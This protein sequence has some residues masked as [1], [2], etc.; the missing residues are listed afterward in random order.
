MSGGT[1]EIKV[2]LFVFIAFI[3]LAVVVFSISDFYTVRPEYSLRVRF[4]FAGGIQMGAPVRMAGVNVGEVKYVHL[5]RDEATQKM[6]AELGIILSREAAIEEDAVA[7]INTLGLIGEKY[8]EIIPGTAGSRV[9]GPGELLMGKDSVPMEQFL[10]AS[11]HAVQQIEQTVA[12][13]NAIL[14]NEATKTAIKETLA[15]A[16]EATAQLSELLKQANEIVAKIRTGEGTVGRLLTQDDLYKDLKELTADLKTHP[17]KLM[18]RPR[19]TKDNRES[20]ESKENKEGKENKE[21]VVRKEDKKG[22]FAF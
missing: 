14:D 2:G 4:N 21:S 9:L 15:N 3:L 10:D 7:Y 8:L 12:S 1:R 16:Q 13:L 22:N 17:W 20:K 5:F 6:L 19:E 18:Y 11:F